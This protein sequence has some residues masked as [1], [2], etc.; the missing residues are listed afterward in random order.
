VAELTDQYLKKMTK[1]FATESSA[2]RTVRL[3][4]TLLLTILVAQP[5][6]DLAWQTFALFRPAPVPPFS[7]PPVPRALAKTTDDVTRATELHLFGQAGR[8]TVAETSQSRFAPQTTLDLTLKGVIAA[9]P[10]RKAMAIISKTNAKDDEQIY[11][12]GDKVPG[13]AVIREILA[14]RVVLDRAGKPE[15]LL[16]EKDAGIS[17]VGGVQPLGDD[18]HWQMDGSFLDQ[19]LADL[20]NLARRINFIPYLKG[21]RQQGFRVQTNTKENQ[22]LT[23]LGLEPNDIVYEVNGIWL[24]EPSNAWKVYQL[25]KTAPE[26]KLAIGRDNR[27][28]ERIYTI[29]R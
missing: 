27:R 7:H 23:Q 18:R 26:I 10:M 20:A 5:A 17:A 29:N 14:D 3:V 6:A 2:S 22:L 13:N 15:T 19:Q 21:G 11:A 16:L 12:V 9:H 24:N 25:I 8:V 1:L 28:L 4:I